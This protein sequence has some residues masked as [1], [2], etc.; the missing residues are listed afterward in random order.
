M[1]TVESNISLTN[2]AVA[3]PIAGTVLSRDVS[4]GDLARSQPLVRDR[5]PVTT[6]GG[7]AHVRYRC[8]AHPPRRL[9]VEV[10]R[11]TDGA[12]AYPTGARA[13]GT[14]TASQSTVAR[15]TMVNEDGRWRPGLAVRAR[16][17]VAS[18]RSP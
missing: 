11:L 2:Y 5:G 8:R 17:T 13:A 3:A 10:V 1:A 15:A 16:V 6:V 9:P 4:A 18:S 12:L 7:P 14:A